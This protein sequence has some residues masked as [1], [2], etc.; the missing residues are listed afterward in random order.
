MVGKPWQDRALRD[1]QA[2][3]VILMGKEFDIIVVQNATSRGKDAEVTYN[4]KLREVSDSRKIRKTFGAFFLGGVDKRPDALKPFNI[5]N[6]VTPETKTRIDVLKLLAARYR[7]SNPGGKAQV[8]SF[9]PRPLLKI[10]PPADASDRRVK[11]YT[12]VDAVKALPCHFSAEEVAPIIRRLNPKLLGQ[13]S[14]LFVCLSDDQFREQLRK[15]EQKKSR[16]PGSEAPGSSG[17]GQNQPEGS[18]AGTGNGNTGQ[19]NRSTSS[20]T[21]V[22]RSRNHK[23]GASALIGPPQKK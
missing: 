6:R 17:S 9:D 21:S 15:F 16:Q 18:G 20:F 22:T 8:I 7:A 11:V 5:K 23:R 19:A 12:Y 1:V 14:A 10:Y 13:V 2:V 4:V 3:L